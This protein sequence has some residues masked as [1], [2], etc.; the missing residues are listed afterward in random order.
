MSRP[1]AQISVFSVCIAL[2]SC[3]HFRREPIPKAQPI[4]FPAA[5]TSDGTKGTP[6]QVG[7]I[8]MVNQEGGFVLIEGS[9]LA[10][11]AEGT[12]LKCLR[13]GVEVGVVA[14]GPERRGGMVVADKVTGDPQRGDLVFQ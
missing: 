6:K 4:R 5:N 12:A 7:R 13:D 9:P 11:P 8:V 2:A 10:V 1:L 3:E 14:V